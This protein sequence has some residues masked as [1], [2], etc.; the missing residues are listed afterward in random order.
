MT[1][2]DFVKGDIGARGLNMKT[3]HAE[4]CWEILWKNIKWTNFPPY[5]NQ[6]GTTPHCT[7]V[8]ILISGSMIIKEVWV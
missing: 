4:C 2:V 6:S 5:N 3:T 7:T 8:N 1:W